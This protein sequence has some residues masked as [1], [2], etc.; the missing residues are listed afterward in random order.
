MHEWLLII[1]MF[2]ASEQVQM[3]SKVACIS[4]MVRVEKVTGDEAFC[5]NKAT[6][7]LINYRLGEVEVHSKGA[8]K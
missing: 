3:H 5:I 7:E 6:G 4:A 2:R 1:Y 8:P